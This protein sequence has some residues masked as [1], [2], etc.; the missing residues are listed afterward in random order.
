MVYI[1]F[2]WTFLRD[3][4]LLSSY[5]VYIVGIVSWVL[6]PV[7]LVLSM[8]LAYRENVQISFSAI[9]K[10][11]SLWFSLEALPVQSI[12]PSVSTLTG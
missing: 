4:V 9:E 8:Y 11:S 10:A 6:V 5:L 12:C 1:L 2:S 3:I 7:F